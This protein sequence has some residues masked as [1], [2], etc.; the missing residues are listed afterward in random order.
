MQW[1]GTVSVAHITTTADRDHVDCPGTVHSWLQLSLE[2]W[3]HLLLLVVGPTP[4][5]GST[6]ELALAGG[7]GGGGWVMGEP[8]LRA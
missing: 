2:S 7:S 4:H 5:L 3:P 6:M 1:Q 8:A